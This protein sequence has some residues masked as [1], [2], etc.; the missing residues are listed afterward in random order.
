[1]HV[2]LDVIGGISGD[3]FCAALL[4]AFP[5]LQD[6]LTAFIQQLTAT[7]PYKISCVVAKQHDISG[8]R[9]LVMKDNAVVDDKN[10]IVFTP[11]KTTTSAAMK[12]QHGE[13]AHY[14]WTAI[15]A[16]IARIAD[17]EI[18][19]AVLHIYQALVDA[20]SAVHGVDQQNIHLHEVGAEDAL[21][22]MAS[23]AFLVLRSS[24]RSWSFSPLPWGNGTIRCAHGFLPVPAPATVKILQGFAWKH[25]DEV[26]ERITPTG[27]AILAWL[28]QWKTSG[29]R[30]QLVADG[31]GCGKRQF[32]NT[33]NILRA[34]VFRSVAEN[35][36]DDTRDSVDVVQFDI[37]DMTPEMLAIA[38]QRLRD[39]HAVLDLSSYS[40]SGK[41]G[42]L[43]VRTEILCSSA[44]RDAV[45]QAVFM[46]TSTLGVRYWPCERQ[47]L[48]RRH[49]QTDWQ[50]QQ[51]P[52]KV[53]IRPDNSVT[54]KLEADA[55]AAEAGNY[56]QLTTLKLRIEQQA[57]A[58]NMPLK[59][60]K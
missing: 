12:P 39:H 20:E 15:K 7:T 37:D 18:R 13:H 19:D 43:M 50:E 32:A 10:H 8:K 21:I 16:K 44:A 42:R 29:P 9:F 22:D 60:E 3:M 17:S 35:K 54:A 52:V 31:Y 25:D 1:M 36:P 33:P 2:H 38:Q 27:A 45:C 56:Q 46:L 34:C 11:L 30:G 53:A 47:K 40:I 14:S 4:D 24:V 49:V 57:I 5:E 41:K 6:D 26:G 23:A 51:W 59:E 58:E 55:V 48:V 28:A